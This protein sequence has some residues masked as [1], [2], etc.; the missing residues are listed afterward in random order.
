MQKVEGSNPFSRFKKAR[1]LQGLFVCAVGLWV[2]VGGHPLG[3]GGATRGVSVSEAVE[4][5][6]LCRQFAGDSNH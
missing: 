3:T 4:L 1:L 2:C 6:L 5:R